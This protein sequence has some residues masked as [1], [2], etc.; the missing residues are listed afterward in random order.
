M[1]AANIDSQNY[2]IDS[3]LSLDR[4]EKLILTVAIHGLALCMTLIPF[5]VL[6]NVSY[7]WDGLLALL[8]W[9]LPLSLVCLAI[10]EMLHAVGFII[11]GRVSW[12]AIVVQIN[13]LGLNA[14][15]HCGSPV[16][17]R[18]FRWTAM[19]PALVLAVV[20]AIFSLIYGIGSVGIW[21]FLMASAACSDIRA[22]WLIRH[23]E[24]GASVLHV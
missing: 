10:H 5:C 20:P 11:F 1:S 23:L 15:I 21:S 17:A 3:R 22:V 14:R 8:P 6:W 12:N 18:A 7:L 4:R 16:S 9:V 13:W 24:P 19:L 2:R